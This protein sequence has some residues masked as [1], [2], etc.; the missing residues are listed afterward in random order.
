MISL[1][2]SIFDAKGF[3]NHE[4]DF[5]TIGNG[6]GFLAKRPE[7]SVRREYYLVWNLENL[8]EILNNPKRLTE[9]EVYRKLFG[10]LESREDYGPHFKKNM[11]LMISLNVKDFS[12]EIVGHL[13]ESLRLKF[14]QIEENPYFFQKHIIAYTD[15]Q[16]VEFTSK[17]PM[18]EDPD[19]WIENLET[20]AASADDGWFPTFKAEIVKPTAHKLLTNLFMKLPFLTLNIVPGELADLSKGIEGHLQNENLLDLRDACL[21]NDKWSEQLKKLQIGN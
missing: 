9:S 21:D 5:S 17:W 10:L 3:E 1:L 11:V 15:K 4:F 13:N 18:Q 20:I 16:V 2:K 8:E 12:H 7:N 14:Y 19:F 6:N